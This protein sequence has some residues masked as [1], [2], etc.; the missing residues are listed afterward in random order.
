MANKRNR[1]NKKG[2]GQHRKS[3]SKGSGHLRYYLYY[4]SVAFS[5]QPIL[6]SPKYLSEGCFIGF[7]GALNS[8]LTM[9]LCSSHFRV[10]LYIKIMAFSWRPILFASFDS[11]GGWFSGFSGMLSPNL[12]STNA[13]VISV[14]TYTPKSWYFRVDLYFFHHLTHIGVVF[15]G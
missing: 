8:N 13:I 10:N 4:K 7:G 14:V 5:W 9:K 3:R 6:L 15:L 1:K 2:H 11:Y 12:A